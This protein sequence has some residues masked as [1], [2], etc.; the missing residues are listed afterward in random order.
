MNKIKVM[1]EQSL[2]TKSTSG[3]WIR[4]SD[5]REILV[6][7]DQSANVTSSWGEAGGTG[8]YGYI[9]DADG[10]SIGL[11]EDAY[12]AISGAGGA[13]SLQYGKDLGINAGGTG[14]FGAIDDGSGGFIGLDEA[15]YKSITDAG[16][17]GGLKT[18]KLGTGEGELGWDSMKGKGGLALGVANTGLGLMNFLD[19]KK[20]A[21]IQRDLMKQ[22]LASNA[23]TMAQKRA[24]RANI[25]AAFNSGGQGLKI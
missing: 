15:S 7:D 21:G 1:N 19:S 2:K 22:Q 16:G 12:K 17:A 14:T 24:D 23:E 5:G 20:T 10:K 25:N 3:G 18:Y 9:Y 4:T 8:T 13:D 11:N 6:S